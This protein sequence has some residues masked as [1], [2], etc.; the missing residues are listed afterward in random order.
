MSDLRKYRKNVLGRERV[1]RHRKKRRLD[2]QEAAQNSF[3]GDKYVDCDDFDVQ[4]SVSINE[5]CI[6]GSSGNYSEFVSSQPNFTVGNP[7]LTPHSSDVTSDSSIEAEKSNDYSGERASMLNDDGNS[8]LSSSDG[9]ADYLLVEE[10]DDEAELRA[11]SV[12]E[13][14]IEELED[15]FF[16]ENNEIEELRDW[17][18]RGNPTIH[19]RVDELL[20]ILR[21]RLLPDLPKT[22]K[23]FLQTMKAQ[24][25]IEINEQDA[26][27]FVYFG[28][29][30]QLKRIV[31]PS[32]HN[33]HII[34]LLVNVDGLQLFKSSSKQFW[35]ILCQVFCEENAYKPFPVAIYSGN[36]KP[37]DVNKYLHQFIIEINE[38]QADGLLINGQRFSICIKRFICDRPARAFLKCIKSHG[39]Y[40]ACERCNV[41]GN[42]VENRV[43][44]PVNESVEERTD[45]SFRRQTNLEH[46]TGRSP[47]LHIRPP[48]DMISSFVLDFMHLVYLGV[49]KKLLFYWL[50]GTL[51]TRLS[52]TGK[53]L[54]SDFL[55]KLQKQIPCEFQRTTRSLT[56]IERYKA[57][58]FKFIL[59]YAG[60]I[61]FKKVLSKD[62][63]RHFLLFHT[64]CRILC[65]KTRAVRDCVNAR[66]LLRNFVLLMPR[67][68]GET[69]LIGNVHNLIHLADDVELMGCSI[70]H[71]TAFPFENAL[72]KIKK[73]L[74]NGNKP[75]A[76]ICR[77]LHE[78]FLVNCQKATPEMDL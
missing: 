11:A 10:T 32:L 40:W 75:L 26:S 19:T 20:L 55:F 15:D 31:N 30:E 14:D 8:E 12:T 78:T 53:I 70:S 66:N 41:R 69:S 50:K 18:L 61:I 59:L 22:A 51:K 6:S 48:I 38:L 13:E 42:R 60:P 34:H 27:E 33:D 4:D 72:G 5:E 67:F 64:A 35:P 21:K 24:Y 29:S 7:N 63:Y 54:L 71:Y 77:R 58:E 68:Y 3:S 23:T 1:R 25:D 2:E 52:H 39:G 44:Y 76:Q 28:I 16:L 56:E 45:E 17:A 43:I 47:L 62:I 74:R 73:F 57:I 9:E 65:S 46:H 49:M 37:G 36:H